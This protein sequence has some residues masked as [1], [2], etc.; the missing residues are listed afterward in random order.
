MNEYT[1]EATGRGYKV[2]KNGKCV[3]WVEIDKRVK[4]R[5]N[6]KDLEENKKSA[7]ITIERLKATD[8]EN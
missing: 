3:R 8:K 2:F 7:L 6:K 1:Y 4:Y 5:F